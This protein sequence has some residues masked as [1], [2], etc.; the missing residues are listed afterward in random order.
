MLPPGR[1]DPRNP[2]KSPAWAALVLGHWDTRGTPPTRD[3]STSVPAGEAGQARVQHDPPGRYVAGWGC[4][5]GTAHL[6]GLQFLPGEPEVA[7]FTLAWPGRGAGTPEQP[8]AACLSQERA[9]HPSPG[10][11][12]LSSR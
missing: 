8:R 2:L 6:G 11:L 1:E 4:P 7:H 3:L 9:G 5:P 12:T 10:P